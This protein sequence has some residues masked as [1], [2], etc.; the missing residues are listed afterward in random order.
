MLSDLPEQEDK[1]FDTMRAI[2]SSKDVAG[3]T[4]L[5][6]PAVV[7]TVASS[8]PTLERSIERMG[9]FWT[10]TAASLRNRMNISSSN[11]VVTDIGCGGVV[12]ALAVMVVVVMLLRPVG[13]EDLTSDE[14]SLFGLEI[15]R[16]ER[17]RK[18]RII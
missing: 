2:A 7:S 13:E 15:Q 18:D 8:K 12:I 16:M 1:R 5:R 9:S 14:V 6:P 11:P 3:T 17:R 10:T 4:L